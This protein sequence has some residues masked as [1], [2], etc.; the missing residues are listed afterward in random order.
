ML[1][2]DAQDAFE[3]FAVCDQEPVET[4]AVNDPDPALGERVGARNG[5]RMMSMPSLFETLSKSHSSLGRLA[6]ATSNGSGRM[7]TS[8]ARGSRPYCSARFDNCRLRLRRAVR[9]WGHGVS[10]RRNDVLFFIANVSLS[11]SG[12]NRRGSAPV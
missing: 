1:D 5:V 12:A 6:C 2:I 10:L 7:R 3:L 8:L 11:A 4:V 9:R